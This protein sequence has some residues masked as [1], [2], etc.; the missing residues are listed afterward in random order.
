MTLRVR[1]IPKMVRKNKLYPH[2]KEG[3]RR[4]LQ[5]PF[6][7]LFMEQGTGK[8][9]VAIRTTVE[10]FLESGIH[11]V[12]IF[13]PNNLLYNWSV[14]IKEWSWLPKRKIRVLRLSG[15]KSNWMNQLSSFLQQDPELCTLEQLRAKGYSGKKEDIVRDQSVPLMILLINYEKARLIEPQLKKMKIQSLIVDESQRIKSRNAQV[16][17]AIYRVTRQCKS[18]LLLTGTPIGKG[19]EDLFMQYKVM[20]PTILG[21]DYRD[22]EERYIQKGGYMG[23]QIVGYQNIDELKQLVA[24]TS[25]RVEIEDCIDLPPM[26]FKYLTCELSGEAL[27]AY[28]ELYNDLYTQIPLEASRSRLKAILRQ[29]HIDYHSR[30]SYLSLMLKAEPFLNVASCDLTITKLIRLHQLTGGFLK[31]DS[32]ELIQ[33]GQDKLDLAIEYLKERTR[34]TVVFCNFVEEIRLLEKELK[35]TF[36]KRRIEN[37]R[38]S[39]HRP[40]IERDFK[41]GKVDVVIL[42]IHSGSIGLNFQMADSILLY[43]INH[44][45]DDYW[46]AIARIKRP[47]QK[48]RMEVVSLLCE[49]TVDEDIAEDIRAKTKLIKNF[50]E[51]LK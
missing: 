43:S 5:E 39:K 23:H 44:S 40:Q 45:A 41:K 6:F 1:G 3:V 33:L 14:E 35:K 17:K 30:E 49:N 10:R 15:K 36:P 24:D 29:N 37:Y 31:L 32:G 19:Y 42:Q 2:Q 28:Q 16:S 18:R 38:D 11:R 22:F 50:L 9:A 27:K 48:H 7:A 34:P 25:Y 46:Q 4:A 20:D 13:A 8:T 51:N 21:E 26:D 12:V 47:G